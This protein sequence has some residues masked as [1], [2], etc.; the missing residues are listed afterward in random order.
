MITL[1]I[2]SEFES[3]TEQAATMSE[4]KRK[5]LD[6]YNTKGFKFYAGENEDEATTFHKFFKGVKAD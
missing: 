1:N 3:H 4:L 5:V 2:I 6:G